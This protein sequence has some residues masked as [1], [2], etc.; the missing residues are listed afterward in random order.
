MLVVKGYSQQY[1]M[2]YEEIFAPVAKITTIHILITVA[3]ICQ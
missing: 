2:D 3:S 1:D